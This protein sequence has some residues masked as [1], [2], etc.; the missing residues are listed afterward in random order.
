MQIFILKIIKQAQ[1]CNNLIVMIPVLSAVKSKSY[2]QC[3][4]QK[5]EDLFEKDLDHFAN[6]SHLSCPK[7]LELPIQFT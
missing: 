7:N 3:F 6:S 2:S 1:M 5:I 4:S